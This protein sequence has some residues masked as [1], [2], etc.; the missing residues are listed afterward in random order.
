MSLHHNPESITPKEVAG[1]S[2]WAFK[3]KYPNEAT[4]S[5]LKAVKRFPKLLD[6][7]CTV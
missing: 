1:I 4:A 6:I 7:E 2:A 5:L 3:T